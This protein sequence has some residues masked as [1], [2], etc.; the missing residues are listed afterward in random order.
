LVQKRGERG[1]GLSRQGQGG[2]LSRR[3][4][5]APEDWKNERFHIIG[6]SIDRPS[7]SNVDNKKSKEGKGKEKKNQTLINHNNNNSSKEKYHHISLDDDDDDDPA[8]G[9]IRRV[10]SLLNTKFSSPSRPN[11]TSIS[12]A[13]FSISLTWC[14][15]T[16]VNDPW[17]RL[18]RMEEEAPSYDVVVVAVAASIEPPSS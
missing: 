8:I 12:F 16:A 10:P 7:F 1:R 11:R 4:I 2:L 14:P 15:F 6:S 5:T 18:D 3:E 13:A 9:M 17:P